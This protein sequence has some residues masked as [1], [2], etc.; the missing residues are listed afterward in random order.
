MNYIELLVVLLIAGIIFSVAIDSLT[1]VLF[2]FKSV[3]KYNS[4]TISTFHILNYIRFDYV[5]HATE[6]PN[7]SVGTVLGSQQFLRF[8]EFIEGDKKIVRYRVVGPTQGKFSL[9][10]EVYQS[11]GKSTILLNRRDFTLEKAISFSLS[12]DG[13]FIHINNDLYGCVKIPSNPPNVRISGIIVIKE[14]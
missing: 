12:P 9:Y 14:K 8:S 4:E 6:S 5:N 1:Q 2:H 7:L 11:Y 10:R 13:R 3:L